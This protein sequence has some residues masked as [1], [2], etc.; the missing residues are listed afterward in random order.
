MLNKRNLDDQSYRSIVEAAMGRLPWI[1]P[2]WTDHNSHDPGVT[3]LELMAWYKEMQQ[4]QMNQVTDLLK[5]KLLKTVGVYRRA[6]LPATCAV[7]L[8]EDGVARLPLTRLAL[9]EGIMFE[10][11]EAIPARRP[12]IE[13]VWA[14]GVE[15]TEMLRSGGLTFRPF[16]T[17]RGGDTALR[18]AVR[19]LA[20]G[21]LRLWFQVVPPEGTPRNLFE[22]D[23][24]PRL[25]RWSVDGLGELR[26]VRDETHS[27]SQSGFVELA[28]DSDW[29]RSG[30]EGLCWLEVRQVDPGCEDPVRLADVSVCRWTV[31]QQE[32]RAKSHSFAAP[33]RSQWEVLLGDAMAR[34]SHPVCFIRR[35]GGWEQTQEFT[36]NRSV[37]GLS[38]CLNTMELEQDGADNICIVCL[39][40]LRCGELLF[41][42]KGLPGETLTL[43]LEGQ[44]VL[45]D[46]FV[47]WCN[48]LERDGV[49]R[50]APWRCVSD[51]GAFGPRDR[52]FHYDPV[53]ETITFGDGEH[54]AV[55]RK[56]RGSVLI[57]D[58]VLS[59]CGDGNIPAGAGLRFVE[60]GTLVEN[61][62][63]VGGRDAETV[64]AAAGRLL[65]ELKETQKCVSAEDYERLVRTTP[66]LRVG[67]VKAIAG[68][69]PGEPS[70]VSRT[71]VVTVVAAPVSSEP[72]PV[73]DER[74]LS[75]IRCRLERLRPVCTR[76]HVVPPVY[77]EMDAE[78]SIR[79]GESVRQDVVRAL[80]ENY[81]AQDGGI[82]GT[83]RPSELI[84]R[85]QALPGVG[86]VSKLDIR[87]VQPGC[88]QNSFGDIQLP[89]CGVACLRGLKLEIV[90]KTGLY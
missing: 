78:I 40:P 83:I 30:E 32:T 34:S 44:Q 51:L 59:A 80:V 52:V 45:Q 15:L 72:R 1:C 57:A 79:G 77:Q 39:D 81:L 11:D 12:V 70:G 35:G 41:D 28:A 6:A 85:L 14:G 7:M 61:T 13:Q 67:A 21:P 2:V 10:L 74:F 55:V 3:V 69:D 75:Q 82:G 36:A 68:Y 19:D 73:P 63:A 46:R 29:P 38:V 87:P 31:T 26:P 62:A 8:K 43:N 24:Q 53:R 20:D 16:A 4:Y 56:G 25:L 49:V 86:L 66:G 90:D 47:L 9:A 65:R 22:D 37:Q 42:T 23:Y 27:F 71:P 84:A 18:I 33:A 89:K 76:V 88:Y 50:V 54:G 64:E 5:E 48:T 58:M 60:E 17:G